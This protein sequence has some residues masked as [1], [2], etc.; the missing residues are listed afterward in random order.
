MFAVT[1]A[2]TVPGTQPEPPFCSRSRLL[3]G[4]FPQTARLG[5]TAALRMRL[6][7]QLNFYHFRSDLLRTLSAAEIMC[8]FYLCMD[9]FLPVS[10]QLAWTGR[11][12]LRLLLDRIGLWGTSQYVLL[13]G[14]MESQPDRWKK[15]KDGREPSGTHPVC[16]VTCPALKNV[17]TTTSTPVSLWFYFW[18]EL[19]TQAGIFW[20]ET[21]LK[22]SHNGDVKPYLYFVLFFFKSLF[23]TS[24][25]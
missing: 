10:C 20:H 12:P 4:P 15:P 13:W 19:Q 8:S 3:P 11:W 23:H 22:M 2:H 18:G 14:V 17:L 7:V 5:P 21:T 1:S 9:T 6:V 25:V 24:K 16:H